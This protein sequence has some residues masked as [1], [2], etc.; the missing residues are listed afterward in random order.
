M[1]LSLDL[2]RS[3]EQISRAFFIGF[4]SSTITDMQGDGEVEQNGSHSSFVNVNTY[5]LVLKQIKVKPVSWQ[6]YRVIKTLIPWPKKKKTLIL[7]KL[8]I[9]YQSLLTIMIS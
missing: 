3:F 6:F 2:E 8:C 9:E 1:F 4:D 7:H 5:L